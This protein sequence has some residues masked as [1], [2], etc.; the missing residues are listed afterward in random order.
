MT[1]KITD[2][3]MVSVPKMVLQD[4]IHN[5]EL[6]TAGM[7]V[8]EEYVGRQ[9]RELQRHIDAAYPVMDETEICFDEFSNVEFVNFT[10]RV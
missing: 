9:C 1:T 3:G 10:K 8:G 5:C 2:E 6:A 4:L 7:G